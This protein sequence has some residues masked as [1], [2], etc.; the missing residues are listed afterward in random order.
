MTLRIRLVTEKIW[1]TSRKCVFYGIFKNTTKHQKI[2][3]ETF[4][5]MQPNTWK[6]FLFRKISIFWKYFYTNQRSLRNKNSGLLIKLLWPSYSGYTEDNFYILYSQYFF[7][8]TYDRYLISKIRL[9]FSLTLYKFIVWACWAKTQFCLG[10]K[11][12]LVLTQ[13]IFDLLEILQTWKYNK[14]MQFNG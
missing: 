8:T 5:E 7:Q 1:A 12:K 10:S 11:P 4:F 2:F 3:S 13:L 6:Y 9:V 14:N